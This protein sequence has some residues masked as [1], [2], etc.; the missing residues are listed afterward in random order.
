M[1]DSCPISYRIRPMSLE[2]HLFEVSL[3]VGRPAR[4]GQVLW[5]PAWIPGS[6]MIRDF[7]RNIVTLTACCE[8]DPVAVTKLDKQTWRCTPCSGPLEVDYLVYGWDLSVRAAHLDTTRAYF[9]GTSVFLAVKGQ[10]HEPCAV[11]IRP[12]EG[13][14]YL[15][16]RLATTLPRLAAPELGF[17]T[18]RADSYDTLIDHPVEMGTFALVDFE[19][20]RV[21]HRIAITGRHR[22]DSQRLARDLASICTEHVALFGGDLPAQQYL[23]QVSAVGDGYGGLEHRDSS[24]LICKRDDLPCPGEG[25]PGAGY[26][27]FLG[28]CSH[29]YFHLWNVK[30]IVPARFVP[31]DL[32]KEVHTQLLWVF[33]GFTSYYDD[34]ALV[35]CGCIQPESYLESLA[36]TVTRVMRGTGRLKQSVAESSFD[37]W[38]KF[39]K[40]D[41]N[42]SNAIV[43]YY[44]KGALVAL[45]LDLSIRVDTGGARSLDDVM[46]TLWQR[47]GAPGIGVLEDGVERLVDEVS[48]LDMKV[49]FSRYVHGTEDPPLESLL[50]EVGVGL[51]L[52]PARGPQDF[53]GLRANGAAEIPLRLS[54]GARYKTVGNF[55]EITVVPDGSPAQEAGLSAGDRILAVDGLRAGADNLEALVARLP[56]GETVPAHVFRRDE[57]MIFNLCPDFPPADTCELWLEPHP[58]AE[59]L[60]RRKAWLHRED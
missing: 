36:E 60:A 21:P 52:R 38:S 33:E 46:R 16:W 58:G 25:E 40:Q 9:N 43:S 27:R 39:Y 37:A 17:G 47:H 53:G 15:G 51:R 13:D 12:P 59:R 7:A 20:T 28:L 19:A 32:T 29:E 3:R 49:F 26:R 1:P 34:L 48:G 35:R 22:A 45:A 41:E 8:T 50:A 4:D 57:L 54:L 30:R 14:A 42:A 5:L 56:R 31:Y 6:Y 55:A 24:S 2:A 11:D 44:A 18:Y 23:F 10:E